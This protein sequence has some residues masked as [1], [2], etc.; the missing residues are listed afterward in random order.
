[1]TRRD[2]R[3]VT[4]GY[5]EAALL[6]RDAGFQ[7]VEVHL[8]HG[9]LLHQFISPLSNTRDDAYGGGREGRRRYPLEVLDAVLDAVGTTSWSGCG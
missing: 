9:H 5:V 1:M 8:G 2:L 6:A 4:A 3:A 7:G